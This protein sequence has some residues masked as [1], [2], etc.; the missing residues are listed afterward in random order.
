MN[1]IQYSIEEMLSETASILVDLSCLIEDRKA[2]RW[3]ESHE[4]NIRERTE[5]LIAMG[6]PIGVAPA[7]QR[8]LSEH[9]VLKGDSQ[10]VAETE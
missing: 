7:I 3:P 8:I 10:D 6:D 4:I 9:P 5:Q 1:A 2:N